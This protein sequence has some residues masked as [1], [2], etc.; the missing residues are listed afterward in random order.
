MDINVK[1]Y[2]V[3]EKE[4][5]SADR[6][7]QA[8]NTHDN[9]SEFSSS[10]SLIEY[11]L[12]HNAVPY[13]EHAIAKLLIKLE[14]N[15]K[16]IVRDRTEWSEDQKA[17]IEFRKREIPIKRFIKQTGDEPVF[18]GL[19]PIEVLSKTQGH[20][21]REWRERV[22]LQL[23]IFGINH[24]ITELLGFLVPEEV[25]ELCKKHTESDALLDAICE[26][27]EN[28]QN[29]YIPPLPKQGGFI[30]IRCYYEAV[31]KY[32]YSILRKNKESVPG[33][34]KDL[35]KIFIAGLSYRTKARY[36]LE[37]EEDL[38]TPLQKM[39]N[40][41]RVILEELQKQV[42]RKQ[43]HKKTHSS[44]I[45][46]SSTYSSQQIWCSF[47]NRFGGHNDSQCIRK[48]QTENQE[49][50]QE[51]RAWS[52]SVSKKLWCSFH[53]RFGGHESSE[54]IQKEKL[55]SQEIRQESSESLPKLLAIESNR[56]VDFLLEND[57]GMAHSK[58]EMIKYKERHVS[59]QK[60]PDTSLDIEEVCGDKKTQREQTA[61]GES[62]PPIYT[63]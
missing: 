15:G 49:M 60:Y 2:D 8:F 33:K 19:M 45:S 22:E 14:E 42:M 54:C 39:E 5:S 55:E 10:L 12:K 56:E 30:F 23:A 47:H 50:S 20:C 18:S 25:R 35:Q 4:S 57:E 29:R 9:K 63:D 46:A 41:E 16:K 59:I 6:T 44:E 26:H 11:E 51:R 7:F 40:L 34:E 36:F 1:Q 3:S 37:E 53:K 38:E 43:G 32:F 52:T 31:K 58:I 13:V 61:L 48:A 28:K 21:V 62:A 27:Y 24:K 17:L